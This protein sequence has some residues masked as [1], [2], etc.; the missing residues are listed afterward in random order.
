MAQCAFTPIDTI[1]HNT[2]RL[3]KRWY[4]ILSSR[5][6]PLSPFT[7]SFINFHRMETCRLWF[8]EYVL[9]NQRSQSIREAIEQVGKCF[10]ERYLLKNTQYSGVTNGKKPGKLALKSSFIAARQTDQL[11]LST[12]LTDLTVTKYD[13]KWHVT[14]SYNRHEHSSVCAPFEKCIKYAF[15]T[16]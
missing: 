7:L 15:R 12:R 3:E 5:N 8:H 13:D 16:L 10:Q 4:T 11:W 1:L 6:H 2:V 9:L 14:R